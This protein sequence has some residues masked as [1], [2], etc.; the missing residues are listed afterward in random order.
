MKI[1]NEI[2]QE[3]VISFQRYK[4]TSQQ[5]SINDTPELVKIR[6]L[7]SELTQNERAELIAIM[8]FGRDRHNLK[9]F[10]ER[11]LEAESLSYRPEQTFEYLISQ[12]NLDLYMEVGLKRLTQTEQPIAKMYFDTD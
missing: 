3:I 11:N 2:V 10:A 1:K 8:E 12:H 4:L 9:S 6:T 7:V 5:L